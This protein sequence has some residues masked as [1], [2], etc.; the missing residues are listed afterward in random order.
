MSLFCNT[1]MTNL[2]KVKPE[3][4]FI[5]VLS[6]TLTLNGTTLSGDREERTKAAITLKCCICA[7]GPPGKPMW[8][9][10]CFEQCFSS[11]KTT[12]SF[13]LMFKIRI[14]M[15]LLFSFHVTCKKI[16]FFLL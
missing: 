6:F 14:L 15:V 4:K 2:Y 9:A 13:I 8:S 7:R 16:F 10:D 5:F 11:R 3:L 12:S 1:W